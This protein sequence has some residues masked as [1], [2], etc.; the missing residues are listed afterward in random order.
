MGGEDSLVLVGVSGGSCFCWIPRTVGAKGLTIE[1]AG[2][3]DFVVI[4][5][6]GDPVVMEASLAWQAWRLT[7]A[8]TD[9]TAAVG[10]GGFVGRFA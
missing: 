8:S 7:V 6:G 3:R 10:S 2:G 1:W 9:S 4:G 5:F